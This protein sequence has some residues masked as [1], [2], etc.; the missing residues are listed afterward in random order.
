[1][2]HVREGRKMKRATWWAF[3]CWPALVL[4]A[5][6]CGESEADRKQREQSQRRA[7]AQRAELSS[8]RLQAQQVTNAVIR[9]R[10]AAAAK[11]QAALGGAVTDLKKLGAPAVQRLRDDA[12]K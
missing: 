8:D 10:K 4:L 9:A 5:S 11:D 12:A 2:L 3:C 7:E 6:G 1:M